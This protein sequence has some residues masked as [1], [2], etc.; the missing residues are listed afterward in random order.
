MDE[1]PEIPHELSCL[2]GDRVKK[3]TAELMK[4]V[5]AKVH[6]LTWQVANDYIEN[7][8]DSEPLINYVDR[9]EDE[10]QRCASA[11]ADDPS[12]WRGKRIR[13]VIFEEHKGELGLLINQD[14]LNDLQHAHGEKVKELMM[15]NDY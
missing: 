15:R 10:V 4:L 14:K 5:A 6:D 13:E 11:W 1:Y 2:V 3:A 8:G 7:Y 12:N 9:V